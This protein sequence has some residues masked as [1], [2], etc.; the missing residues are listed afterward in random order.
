MKDDIKFTDVSLAYSANLQ[1]LDE[2]RQIF[3]K[4]CRNLNSI[5]LDLATEKCGSR[6]KDR[7]A[8]L[9]KKFYWQDI[10]DSE[11]SRR[12]SHWLNFSQGTSISISLKAPGRK[13]FEKDKAYLYFDISFDSELKRYM[14]N[15]HFRNDYAR[16]DQL[17]ERLFSLAQSK[18]EKF[19]NPKHIKQSCAILG[20]W[21]L[22]HELIENLNDIVISS[23][24][25]VQEMIELELP[26]ALYNVATEVES[27]RQDQRDPAA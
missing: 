1:N 19:P 10:S 17:D 7:S 8:T 25:L 2:A 6:N 11:S 24:D 18:P 3:E 21:E 9:R 12:S 5:V 26:D 27:D 14:F 22:N 20:V 4:E 13:N 15:V 16:N 23:L